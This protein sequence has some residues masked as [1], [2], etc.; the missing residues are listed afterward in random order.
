MIICNEKWA[1]E[2]D[3]FNDHWLILEVWIN[4]TPLKP[5]KKKKLSRIARKELVREFLMRQVS[6]N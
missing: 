6:V 2:L 4:E 1:S 5:G 3:R